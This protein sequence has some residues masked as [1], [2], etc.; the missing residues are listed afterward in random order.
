MCVITFVH[1]KK[2]NTWFRKQSCKENNPNHATVANDNRKR[3]GTGN[4]WLL[5]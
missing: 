4:Y 3:G 2:Y 5:R 1:M